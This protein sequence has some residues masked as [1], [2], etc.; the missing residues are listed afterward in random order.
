MTFFD[1]KDKKHPKGHFYYFK[2]DELVYLYMISVII[3]RGMLFFLIIYF[4]RNII[5]SVCTS[6]K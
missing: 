2:S 6:Q 4:D 5:H 3:E 1:E